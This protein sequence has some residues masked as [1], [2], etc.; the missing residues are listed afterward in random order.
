MF[1]VYIFFSIGWRHT[2]CALWT[3]VQSW[4]LPIYLMSYV[5]EDGHRLFGDNCAACHGINAAGNPGFPNL[6]DGDWLWGGSAY[7]ITHTIA[8][9]INSPASTDTRISQMMAFGRDRKSTR[10]NSSH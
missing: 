5:R 7:A 10:L 1:D 3:V 8:V 9:G 2:I 6:V 4:A